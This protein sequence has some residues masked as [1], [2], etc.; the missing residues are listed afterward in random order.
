MFLPPP[1]WALPNIE[2]PSLWLEARQLLVWSLPL[3]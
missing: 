3:E 1:A 2:L